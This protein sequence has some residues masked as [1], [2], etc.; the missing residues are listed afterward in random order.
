MIFKSNGIPLLYR[1]NFKKSTNMSKYI[2]TTKIF[3]KITIINAIKFISFQRKPVNALNYASMGQQLVS[4]S[5]FINRILQ[6]VIDR[7]VNNND[8]QKL[9]IQ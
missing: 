9:K 2:R 5:Y 4:H 8:S 7:E 3:Q 1:Y 6:N